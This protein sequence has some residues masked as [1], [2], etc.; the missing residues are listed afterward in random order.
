[1]SC[2]IRTTQLTT[3]LALAFECT[4]SG[5]LCA[6]VP[7][8]ESAAP[9]RRVTDSFRE[10]IRRARSSANHI[11]RKVETYDSPQHRSAILVVT[12]CDD[13]GTGSLRDAIANATSGDTIDLS[14][15]A[16]STITLTSGSIGV[17]QDDLSLAGPGSELLSVDGGRK[18]RLFRHMGAGTLKLDGLTLTQGY[19]AAVSAGGGC[20]YSLAN[21]T[22][23]NVTASHC[24]TQGRFSA[25]G[26]IFAY[27]NV[28]VL[29]SVITDNLANGT[30][31]SSAGGISAG[32]LSVMYST[33]SYNRATNEPP[34]STQYA[35][36]GAVHTVGSVIIQNSSVFGNQAKNVAALA[37]EAYGNA[38]TALIINSTV[39]ENVATY[40]YPFGGVY[41]A[42]PLAIYNSTIAFNIGT[43]TSGLIATGAPVV[44]QSSIIAD[45]SRGDLLLVNGATVTG[46]NNLINIASTVPPDTIRDCPRLGPLALN[47]GVTRTHALRSDSPAINAGN[48]SQELNED[49]RGEGFPRVFG[50]A[51]D[52]GAVEWQ[53]A[54]GD[55]IFNSGFEL[56]CDH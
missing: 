46:M 3:C 21:V 43:G 1:M 7:A 9:N 35:V 55:P 26:A 2:T 4:G 29:N 51:A 53:G 45:N 56:I 14:Q 16:C 19:E 36:A 38:P 52:I 10:S 18:V 23:E 28:T 27:G 40:N 39:S 25:G 8:F 41:T 48:N 54:P 42:I 5:A 20:V 11:R 15:L 31:F 22:V 32:D 49:Q 30:Y 24:T 13:Q 37:F 34:A 47:G 17:F 44:L 12:N 33:I 6:A 50:S